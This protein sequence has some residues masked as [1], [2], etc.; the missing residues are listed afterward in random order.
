MT[1]LILVCTLH[2]TGLRI[3]IVIVAPLYSLFIHISSLYVKYYSSIQVRVLQ[4][5]I[6]TFLH[7]LFIHKNKAYASCIEDVVGY[8]LDNYQGCPFKTHSHPLTMVNL[9]SSNHL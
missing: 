7:L 9:A 5:K 3:I 4:I 6:Q 2:C 8:T 1:V